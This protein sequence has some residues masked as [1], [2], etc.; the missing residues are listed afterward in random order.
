LIGIE[1]ER[2]NYFFAHKTLANLSRSQ[3][4]CKILRTFGACARP[5][6]KQK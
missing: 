5:M 4:L 1:K 2:I 6:I 3:R